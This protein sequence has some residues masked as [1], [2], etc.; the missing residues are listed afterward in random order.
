MDDDVELTVILYTFHSHDFRW[1]GLQVQA[2][3]HFLPEVSQI[4]VTQGP[5]GNHITAAGHARLADGEDKRFGVTLLNAPN[6]FAGLHGWHR[7]HAIA[8]WAVQKMSNPE[9]ILCHGDT[10]PVRSMA[11]ADILGNFSAAGRV[12]RQPSGIN[13]APLTWLAWRGQFPEVGPLVPFTGRPYA[14]ARMLKE[15]LGLGVEWCDPGWIHLDKLS[16]ATWDGGEEYQRRKEAAMRMTWQRIGMDWP[17]PVKAMQPSR[18]LGD[19]VAKVIHA[20][21]GIQPC[22]ECQKQQNR[23]NR[24]FPYQGAR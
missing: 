10:I 2:V 17:E 18:G 3:R 6:E 16:M 12:V 5:F 22:D 9:G 24:I 20:V 19:T 7:F 15:F 4:V 8:R 21:T 14:T 11:M 23:L 13:V 1:L